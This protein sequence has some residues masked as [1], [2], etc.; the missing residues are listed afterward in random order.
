VPNQY[1]TG[2]TPAG[3]GVIF[4]GF[5][6]GY[7]VNTI[8]GSTYTGLYTQYLDIC[9]PSL[10]QAQYVRDGN[11]NQTVIRRDLIA[12]VYI[13]TEVSLPSA[14]AIGTRPFTI[15]RQ[16]KNAKVRLKGGKGV[17]ANLWL[18]RRERGE[19][20]GLPSVRQPNEANVSDQSELE[21]HLT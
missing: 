5:I 15:H 2:G 1:P 6:F 21:S 11:T 16:F 7:G 3:T 13:A 14:D 9:S 19:E 4:P 8:V 17:V 10:C 20:C 18:G 12:R